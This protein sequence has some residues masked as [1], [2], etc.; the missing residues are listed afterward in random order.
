MKQKSISGLLLEVSKMMSRKHYNEIAKI[1]NDCNFCFSHTDTLARELAEFFAR[2]NPRF[3]M[4][5]FLKA[6]GVMK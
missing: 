3:D 6:C 2:D 1:I 4:Y 5:R